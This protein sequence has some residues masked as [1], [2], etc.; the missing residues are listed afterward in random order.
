MANEEMSNEEK[1]FPVAPVG[2]VR[3]AAEAA[4]ELYAPDEVEKHAQAIGE[5]WVGVLNQRTK[6]YAKRKREMAREAGLEAAEPAAAGYVWWNLLLGG[7]FQPV[8]GAAAG[9]FLPHKII[10]AGEPAFMLAVLWR[11]P[12]PIDGGGGPSASTVMIPYN[13]NIWFETIN[14][15]TVTNGPD[16]GPINANFGAGIFGYLNWHV[17][18]I[19][20]PAP[21]EGRPNLYEMNMTVDITQA[22]LPFAGFSTWVLD[23]DAEAPF[24]GPG[25][26]WVFWDPDIGWVRILPVPGA[27]GGLQHDTPARFLV[28]TA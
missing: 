4:A 13:Y 21:P 20:F 28:Y 14:L 3:Q 5:S 23:P 2:T 16:F 17:I 12:D 7:P 11:N 26:T 1:T 10:R 19:A 15:T 25:T 24:G 18:P 6:M 9:P 8:A 27:P 22:G